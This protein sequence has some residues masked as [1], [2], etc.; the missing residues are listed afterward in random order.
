M[1]FVIGLLTVL[2]V[3]DCLFLILLVLVQLPKKEAGAGLAFGGAATDALFGAGS[4]NALTKITKYAAV[5]FFVLLLIIA[6]TQSG[7]RS[8][9]ASGFE[10]AIEQENKQMPL[11]ATA[12][13]TLPGSNAAPVELQLPAN[14]TTP[15]PA[16]DATN[17]APK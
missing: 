16:T 8:G 5:A 17:G 11:P 13:A 7:S 2:L 3:L 6:V 1:F 4:G 10:K 12:P 9:R 15:A 14:V